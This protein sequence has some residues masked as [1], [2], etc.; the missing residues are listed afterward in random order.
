MR[1][2][3]LSGVVPAILTPFHPDGAIDDKGVQALADRMASID[4][5][6]AVFCTGHAGEVA[7]MSREERR[8]VTR[9]TVEAV[10][11]RVPVI[12][13][14]YTDSYAD[15]VAMARDAREAGASAVTL[16]APPVFADGATESSEAPFRFF[17]TVAQGAEI[18]LVVFQFPPESGLGYDTETLVRLA[19][20]PEVVAVKEGSA[21]VDTYEANL[22]ALHAVDPPVP[23]L[24]SN[25]SW[26]LPSLSV[27]GD[28][29]LSGASSVVAEQHVELWRCIERLDLEGARRV[30]DRLYPL[31]KA[32]Y[33][34]PFIDMHNRMKEAL[35]LMGVLERATVRPPLM[36]LS[37]AEKRDI[38]AALVA[39]ELI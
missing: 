33:R 38:R 32:F 25:N 3:S 36:P 27:G 24:T 4:G 7:A 19:S 34:P 17:E 31:V 12:A 30:N 20:L 2:P 35:V 26:L 14:V 10:G 15:A 8:H 23:V 39:A 37:D 16:F 22:R 9:L 11:G 1:T 18:P 28:G 21:S 5:V 29:I 13:G 6:G